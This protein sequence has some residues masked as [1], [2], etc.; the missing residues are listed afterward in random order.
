MIQL[1]LSK[2]D[3]MILT[4]GLD[5]LTRVFG[6]QLA[7]TGG[8]AT[9]EVLPKLSAIEAVSGKLNSALASAAAN[10]ADRGEP[11]AASISN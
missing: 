10:G 5:V 6:S 1:D 4:A 2:D 9:N 7:N 11:T 3:A 8:V